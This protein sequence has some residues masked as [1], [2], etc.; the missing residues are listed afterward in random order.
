MAVRLRPR[1]GFRRDH[2]AAAPIVDHY[3]LA[4]RSGE[5]LRN[6]ARAE[7]A[8]ACYRTSNDAYRFGRIVLAASETCG[9]CL[10]AHRKHP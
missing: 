6:Q 10:K 8:A 9:E 3:R 2:Y 5:S 1:H 7:I 4:Q